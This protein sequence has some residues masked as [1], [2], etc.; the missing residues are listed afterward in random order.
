LQTYEAGSHKT[1]VH[2]N[3]FFL[4]TPHATAL[5]DHAKVRENTKEW[6]VGYVATK[7]SRKKKHP[8]KMKILNTK[9]ERKKRNW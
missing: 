8:S 4:F 1:S 7:T 6:R 2:K 3:E 5:Y 9:K